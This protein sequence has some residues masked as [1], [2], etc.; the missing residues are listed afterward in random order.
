[1]ALREARDL[2]VAEGVDE[3]PVVVAD[4]LGVAEAELD[5]LLDEL[6]FLAGYRLDD[7][8]LRL[9]VDQGRV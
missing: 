5:H 6:V 9:E 1:M 8:I 3:E 2:A 4:D 7:L